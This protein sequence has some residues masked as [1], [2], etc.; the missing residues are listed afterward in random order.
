[1]LTFRVLGLQ[2]LRLMI[3][4][5]ASWGSGRTRLLL[6]SCLLKGWRQERFMELRG[7][8]MCYSAVQE[9]RAK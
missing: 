9:A 1:V 4:D 5:G 2:S 6:L 7:W 3:G 8:L